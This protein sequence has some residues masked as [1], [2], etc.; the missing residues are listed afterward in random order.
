MDALIRHNAILSR[1]CA[2]TH[3]CGPKDRWAPFPCLLDKHGEAFRPVFD[4]AR[5][6]HAKVLALG[7]MLLSLH[8]QQV[9]RLKP[10]R[11]MPV[12]RLGNGLPLKS[13]SNGNW[14]IGHF[15]L[16][17]QPHLAAVAATPQ[18]AG[19]LSDCVLIVND[20]SVKGCCCIPP[21]AVRVAD[22]DNCFEFQR[23]HVIARIQ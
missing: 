12:V 7:P 18:A 22:D 23:R 13:L 16:A 5:Q 1:R 21:S 10:S 6:E 11:A 2:N 3:A 20:V 14:L 4:M 19:R 15:R 9:L 17:H 8:S